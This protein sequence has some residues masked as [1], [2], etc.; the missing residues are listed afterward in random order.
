MDGLGEGPPESIRSPYLYGSTDYD[1][2]FYRQS[3]TC[4]WATR[5]IGMLKEAGEMMRSQMRLYNKAAEGD[6][7]LPPSAHLGVMGPHHQLGSFVPASPGSLLT[8]SIIS[9]HK[10]PTL[11]R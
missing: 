6:A 2:A 11:G 8:F 3:P 10:A 7:I 5:P 1:L 4:I 9:S